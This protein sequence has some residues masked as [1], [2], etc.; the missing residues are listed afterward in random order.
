[1]GEGGKGESKPYNLFLH[2]S[3]PS[4]IH[5]WSLMIIFFLSPC[6][7]SSVAYLYQF[8]EFNSPCIPASS[9][10]I[11][12][13]WHVFDVSIET[14]AWRRGLQTADI[15]EETIHPC[16][17]IDNIPGIPPPLLNF[18]GSHI[19][20]G[21]GGQCNP[22]AHNYSSTCQMNIVVQSQNTCSELR[23]IQVRRVL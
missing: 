18:S 2:I 20:G 4:M 11:G 12:W 7:E 22:G 23:Y 1:M 14:M 5:T 16:N 8:N 3:K 9:N 19:L 15:L 17:H 21:G 10:Y 13:R 6:K